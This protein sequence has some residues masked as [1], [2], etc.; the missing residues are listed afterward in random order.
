MKTKLHSDDVQYSRDHA[1]NL[2]AQYLRENGWK[3]T[4][5]TPGSFW[6]WELRLPDGRHLLV[7]Q[8]KAV[9]MTPYIIDEPEAQEGK[10][11]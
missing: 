2:A 10:T 5:S 9:A 4:S 11:E 7:P 6:L 3:H 1:E 8:K